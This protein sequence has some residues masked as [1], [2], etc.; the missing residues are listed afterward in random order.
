MKKTSFTVQN[1][2]LTALHHIIENKT[3]FL[4]N[5]AMQLILHYS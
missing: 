4:L 5:I 1:P 2:F 3:N